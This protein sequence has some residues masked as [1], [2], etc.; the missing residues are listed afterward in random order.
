MKPK[1][2]IFILMSVMG[3]QNALGQPSAAIQNESGGNTPSFECQDG[4]LPQ[5]N[6]APETKSAS[7]YTQEEIDGIV[8]KMATFFAI[9]HAKNYVATSSIYRTIKSGDSYRQLY[10][11]YGLWGS[12]NF[13]THPPKWYF[14]SQNLM[15]CFLP[16]DSYV[17][18]NY[19]PNEN[20][21]NTIYRGFESGATGLDQFHTNFLNVLNLYPLIRKQA[22]EYYTPL[23]LKQK[24]NFDCRI[25]RT[26]CDDNG[27]VFVIGFQTKV[28]AFP[29]RTKI[30]GSGRIFVRENGFPFKVE[31]EDAEDRY[32]YFIRS[33]GAPKTLVTP[34]TFTVEYAMS[35]NQI[36][37][38]SV[39][40]NV[41]WELPADTE[42][43]D[44]YYI[45]W[46][47][48]KDP[49]ANKLSTS[50][51]IQ[52]EDPV[53]LSGEEAAII[54]TYFANSNGSD[55]IVY[56][57]ESINKSFWDKRL[58]KINGFDEIERDLTATGISLYEQACKSCENYFN[59]PWHLES[60]KNY[61]VSARR[62][63]EQLYDKAY[64]E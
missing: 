27:K 63:Y 39:S 45:E 4:S 61:Y 6:E 9:H 48:W 8:E 42:G 31:I 26:Y 50:T 43:D 54:R 33:K 12:F 25:E 13:T 62:L 24:K 38:K 46:N 55:E 11:A 21:V 53:F 52:F 51:S 36:Y 22:L 47:T 18:Y 1:L 20:K 32:S 16:L 14:D 37:T 23:N 19:L 7:A 56:Y 15:G 3:I 17:S 40:Q 2:L 29:K 57:V 59:N 5:K 10:C 60:S 35:E 41:R 30:Y 44:F 58:S 64:Y 28:E 34:Y 49:F